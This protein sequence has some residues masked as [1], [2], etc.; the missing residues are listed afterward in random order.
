MNRP[1]CDSA[2][3]LSTRTNG[4]RVELFLW[5][6]VNESSR[7]EL[8]WVHRGVFESSPGSF[9][10]FAELLAQI[11]SDM[12]SEFAGVRPTSVDIQ[13]PDPAATEEDPRG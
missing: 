2:I 5:D 3:A 7:I 8:G 9:D 1:A 10:R 6:R 11:A 4:D 12:I 13:R